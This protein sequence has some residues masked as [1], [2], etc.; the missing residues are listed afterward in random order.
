MRQ[1]V[2]FNR[3]QME[4]EIPL[5]GLRWIVTTNYLLN[6]KTICTSVNIR[7]LNRPFHSHRW[8][9][10]Q[11]TSLKTRSDFLFVTMIPFFLSFFHNTFSTS[12]YLSAMLSSATHTHI[13]H[14]FWPSLCLPTQSLSPPSITRLILSLSLDSLRSPSMKWGAVS[15]LH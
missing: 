10:S 1:V 14:T 15:W 7:I 9:V 12:L 3:E 2:H 5:L 4:L 13:V 8:H 11:K 6:V